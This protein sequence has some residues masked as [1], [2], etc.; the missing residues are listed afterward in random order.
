MTTVECRHAP[1]WRLALVTMVSI[2]LVV[3][4]CGTTT[5]AAQKAGTGERRTDIDPLVKR[6]PLLGTPTA[7]VWYSG[8]MG[9]A[10]VPG[11]TTYW[12]DAVVTVTPATAKEIEADYGVQPTA[13][14]P[15]VVDALRSE[16]PS[17]LRTSASLDGAL[18]QGGDAESWTVKAYFAPSTGQVVLSARGG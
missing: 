8:T 13:E 6:F 2:A 7:A 1:L 14:T 5:Q 10:R 12:I 9:E 11:P 4:G 16:L 17:D 15:D 18:A 3:S